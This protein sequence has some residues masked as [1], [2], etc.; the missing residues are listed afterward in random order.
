MG[1]IKKHSINCAKLIALTQWTDKGW[2]DI[3]LDKVLGPS[4]HLHSFRKQ[5]WIE[6]G[7]PIELPSLWVYGCQQKVS[8]WCT[9]RNAESQ[10]SAGQILHTPT[11]DRIRQE[12]KKRNI[13]IETKSFW[14][15]LIHSSSISTA[16]SHILPSLERADISRCSAPIDSAYSLAAVELTCLLFARSHLLPNRIRSVSNQWVFSKSL[17][18]WIPMFIESPFLWGTRV[19]AESLLMTRPG[20]WWV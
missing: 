16:S 14:P 18:F 7:L 1:N 8:K 4:E 5:T 13:F 15:N 6:G 2:S 20:K 9:L 10:D 12:M 3:L 17:R 11:L 19:Q